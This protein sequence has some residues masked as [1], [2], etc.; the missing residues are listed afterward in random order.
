MVA[1]RP[2][3]LRPGRLEGEVEGR[4]LADLAFGPDTTTVAFHDLPHAGQADAGTGELAERVQPLERLEQ[5]AA[6]ALPVTSVT[7][8]S[9]SPPPVIWSSPRIPVGAFASPRPAGT[10]VKPVST[11]LGTRSPPSQSWVLR[12]S[13]IS[14]SRLLSENGFS[15]RWVPGSRTPWEPSRPWV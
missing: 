8:P 6:P 14:V 1:P 10:S 4:A 7:R 13:C 12:T 11:I 5:L 2:L 15:M 9:D 3:W